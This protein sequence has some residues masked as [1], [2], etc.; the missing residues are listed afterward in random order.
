DHEYRILE[1]IGRG[2]FGALYLGQS[3]EDNAYV[4]VK[5]VNNKKEALEYQHLEI[6]IQASLSHPNILALHGTSTDPDHI[7]MVMDLCDMG[8]LF[9]YLA[10][11]RLTDAQVTVMFGQ[12]LDA[13]GY[14]HQR[15][16]YHRD[17]KLE[18]ILLYGTDDD[19][20]AENPYQWNIKVADFGLSTR[21]RYNNER[22]CGSTVYLAPEHFF[23]DAV[24]DS[25]AS[26]VWSL[27]IL[28]VYMVFCRHL[29][30][31]ATAKDAAYCRYVHDPAAMLKSALPQ[32]SQDLYHFLV[33]V[34]A[35]CPAD[36]PSVQ[37]MKERFTTL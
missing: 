17:L 9:D 24:I 35:P 19:N 13:V 31:E 18:N 11:C 14:M 25:A 37:E 21:E 5:V 36:R 28:L 20:S 6:D 1:E 8:D 27:G 34:L 30:Q 15:N 4:A 10:H 23:D 3:L 26:D 32:L 12:V 22:G 16:I 29:W 7:Y 2:S 33:V